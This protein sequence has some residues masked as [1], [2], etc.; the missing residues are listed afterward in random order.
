MLTQS[1]TLLMHVKYLSSQ[2]RYLKQQLEHQVVCMSS[3]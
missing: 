3:E 2:I 1:V